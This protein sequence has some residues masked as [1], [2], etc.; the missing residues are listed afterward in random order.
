[1]LLLDEPFGALDAITRTKLQKE[2]AA[3]VRE[4]NKTAVFV[5]HDLQ[6]AFALGTR[7]CLM[8]KGKI[9]L[10]ETPENFMKSDL[11]LARAY[12]ETVNL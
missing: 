1:L 7:I 12:L 4:L 6:E 3:L 8:D 11:P 9:A 10:V 5:T 2:F